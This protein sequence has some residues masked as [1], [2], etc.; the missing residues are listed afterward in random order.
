AKAVFALLS[1]A[2]VC[3]DGFVLMPVE[4][5]PVPCNDKAVG[6]LSRLAVTYIN[7]DRTEG[8][9]FAL[10]RV[11][12]VHLHAQG[13][14]GNV[15]YLDLDVLETKCHTGSPKPWKRCDVRPFMETQVS[16]NCNT[17]ILH[18]PEGYSYLY[19]Y[20][21]ALV[22]DSPENLQKTCPTCPTLL[23][24]DSPEAMRAS[25]M[26]LA[27]YKRKST[28]GVGLGVKKITRA[29]VQVYTAGFCTGSLHGDLY[30][31]PEAHVSCELFKAQVS[32]DDHGNDPNPI[33]SES[34]LPTVVQ[35]EP[36]APAPIDHVLID[37]API[38][39]SPAV[40]PS[41]PLPSSSS[42]SEESFLTQQRRPS[43]AESLFSSSEE[44]VGLV[45]RRPPLNF[46]YQRRERR[47]RQA[48]QE[49]SPSYN[50]VFLADF[51]NGTSP[52]R[53]CPGPARYTTV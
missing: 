50:P 28:L 53:S 19:S 29:A 11:A 40:N 17:T 33:P 6:K 18:T 26:T 46:R 16:G 49:T 52:F 47:K 42:E 20:D 9:K 22:P 31:H 43:L 2:V 24:V 36:S 23:S 25:G 7:E 21:C 27:S 37:P 15:Y 32:T 13:P 8:Y 1:E 51:P 45:A 4:L 5:A 48:L 14:A 35:P 10:N 41:T 39:P 44:I 30:D 12:N 3:G 34:P 38:D